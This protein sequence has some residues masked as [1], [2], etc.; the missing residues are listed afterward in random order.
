MK[1]RCRCD[2][3]ADVEIAIRKAIDPLALYDHP[4][5]VTLITAGNV[6]KTDESPFPDYGPL[7]EAQWKAEG[8]KY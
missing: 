8:Y 5:P 1:V 6:P 2:D 4:Y 3:C 7:Y